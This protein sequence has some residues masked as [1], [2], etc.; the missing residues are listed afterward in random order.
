MSKCLIDYRSA[1][2]QTVFLTVKGSGNYYTI[3]DF[4]F[5]LP[6]SSSSSSEGEE[7]GQEEEEEV[8]E[9]NLFDKVEEIFNNSK[10]DGIILRRACYRLIS[11]LYR[12]ESI[13]NYL[14]V[15]QE[16]NAIFCNGSKFV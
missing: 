1:S 7:G 15:D 4:S 10:L 2:G 5:E 12:D 13:P 9:L 3:G 8:N 14:V 16:L 11:R 6:L